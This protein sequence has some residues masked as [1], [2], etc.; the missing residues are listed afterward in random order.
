[1]QFKLLSI[2]NFPE[3]EISDFHVN[4][5][6]V[7]SWLTEMDLLL[8]HYQD[9]VIVYHVT[10]LEKEHCDDKETYKKCRQLVASWFHQNRH[11]LKEKCRGIILPLHDKEKLTIIEVYREELESFYKVPT[12]VLYHPDDLPL[13]SHAL[14]D[15]CWDASSIHLHQAP[16]L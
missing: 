9:F 2:D 11:L 6:N 13:L 1:M 3:V 12:E 10:D 4:I 8:A 16:A 5:M 14:I 15:D 7:Q